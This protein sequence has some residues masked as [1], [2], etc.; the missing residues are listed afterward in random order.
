MLLALTLAVATVWLLWMVRRCVI[1]LPLRLETRWTTRSSKNVCPF[2]STTYPHLT[3][4][5]GVGV[6]ICR[7]F[8]LSGEALFYKWE[9]ISYGQ[10][11]RV[12]N[13]DALSELKTHVQREFAKQNKKLQAKAKTSGMI[14]RN[15]NARQMPSTSFGRAAAAR[16][17]KEEN[18]SGAQDAMNVDSFGS[19]PSR[20]KL[21]V[22]GM[23]AAG[24]KERRCR[25]HVSCRRDLL[26]LR[27]ID[28]C[29]R[30]S[31]R[32]REVRDMSLAL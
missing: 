12:F 26:T 32:G 23:D 16:P 11:P 30:R 5:D 22:Q 19:A 27:Q 28:I 21:V 24:D 18:G 7:N 13:M 3:R 17:V 31:Q 4:R 10:T 20:V 14:S 25:W 6:T 15:L 8:N 1:K 29:M 9:A 2:T